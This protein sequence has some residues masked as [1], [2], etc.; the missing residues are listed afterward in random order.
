MP[1]NPRAGINENPARIAPAAAP[2]VLAA[3]NT[4]ASWAAVDAARTIHREAMGNV[5]P[6]QAAGTHS[7]STLMTSLSSANVVP[8]APSA[9]AAASSGRTATNAN[10]ISTARI[11]IAI[12]SPA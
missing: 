2:S 9:Y 3:Y 4:P 12:S 11:A 8:P 5:A 6:M 7:S 10:G 1:L